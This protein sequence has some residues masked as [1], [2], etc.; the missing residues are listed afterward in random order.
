[1]MPFAQMAYS[2]IS[3]THYISASLSLHLCYV[4]FP[5]Q[6]A[7]TLLSVH[8]HIALCCQYRQTCAM[9]SMFHTLP[10]TAV[11]QPRRG[12]LALQDVQA[13]NYRSRS[14]QQL[15]RASSPP[16]PAERQLRKFASLPKEGAANAAPV[17]NFAIFSFFTTWF[18]RCRSVQY[19]TVLT[20]ASLPHSFTGVGVCSTQHAWEES[21]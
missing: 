19:A 1:M 8:H 14:L 7:S 13:A 21:L 20:A 18:H 12:C 6:L 2:P 17:R 4:M 5:C 10:S 15:Q 11:N 9:R 3:H 16:K